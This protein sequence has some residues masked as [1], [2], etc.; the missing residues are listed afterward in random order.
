ML[1]TVRQLERQL[2]AAG[3]SE[4]VGIRNDQPSSISSESEMS[5][6]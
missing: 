1:F 4:L 3:E 5:D 2:N 6:V